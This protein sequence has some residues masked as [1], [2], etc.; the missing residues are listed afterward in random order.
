MS[1]KSLIFFYLTFL[2]IKTIY[3]YKNNKKNGFKL[4]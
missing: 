4:L 2:V 1:A 3:L